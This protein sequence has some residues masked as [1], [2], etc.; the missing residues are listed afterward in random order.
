MLKLANAYVERKVLT[1]FVKAIPDAPQ[2]LQASLR[3]LCN[4]YALDTIQKNK[5]WFLEKEYLQPVKTKAIRRLV[6]RLCGEVRE[7]AGELVEAFGVPERSLGKIGVKD[8]SF[9]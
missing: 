9:S 3:L 1:S 2:E 5:G 4:L 7:Q 8:Y 6:E